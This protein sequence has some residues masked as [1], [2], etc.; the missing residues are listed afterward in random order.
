MRLHWVAFRGFLATA[1]RIAGED[2]REVP[3]NLPGMD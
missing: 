2:S 3:F 1:P